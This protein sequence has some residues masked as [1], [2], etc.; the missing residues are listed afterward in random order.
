MADGGIFQ[1]L[2]AELCQCFSGCLPNVSHEIFIALIIFEKVVCLLQVG[3]L[4][5]SRK[6]GGGS[7]VNFDHRETCVGGGLFL[8]NGIGEA[9]RK[10]GV[11][12]VG[13]FLLFF[14][15][16]FRGRGCFRLVF[17]RLCGGVV[18]WVRGVWVAV[19]LVVVAQVLFLVACFVSLWSFLAGGGGSICVFL[20]GWVL[21]G[22]GFWSPGSSVLGG[23]CF[24]EAGRRCGLCP[25]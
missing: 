15:L 11:L 9:C 13:L 5:F 21:G 25:F 19:I 1:A 4:D 24:N 6:E 23:A 10:P 18:L 12:G 16:V 20:F 2:R 8:V 3:F 17:C 22:R 7:H 14:F